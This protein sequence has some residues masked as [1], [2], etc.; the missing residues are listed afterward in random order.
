VL[1]KIAAAIKT[2]NSD[3]PIIQLKL[4]IGSIVET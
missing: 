4:E 2:D 3:D 1:L